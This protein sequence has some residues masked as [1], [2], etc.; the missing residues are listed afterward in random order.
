MVAVKLVKP[1]DSQEKLES[2][3]LEILALTHPPL[4]DHP[5]IIDLLGLTW[6]TEREKSLEPALVVELAEYGSLDKYLL[7]HSL[8]RAAKAKICVGVADGL[9]VLHQCAVIHGDVK[10]ENVLVVRGANDSITPKLSDF[11]FSLVLPQEQLGTKLIGTPRWSA[12]ELSQG[13][14]DRVM[15]DPSHFP[16]LDIYSYGLLVWRVL[17]DGQDPFNDPV[18]TPTEDVLFLKTFTNEPLR[19]ACRDVHAMINKDPNDPYLLGFEELFKETLP[20]DA[21]ERC[22]NLG[23]IK[24]TLSS[25]RG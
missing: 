6:T 5:N 2:V 8:D 14:S 25:Q 7:S 3:C 11:G 18:F 23:W 13:H 4:R 12:P 15:Q 22:G 1:L 16:L 19:R 9:D 10:C 17:K 21:L 20:R 24:N